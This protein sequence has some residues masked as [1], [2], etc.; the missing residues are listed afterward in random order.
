MRVTRGDARDTSF[1]PKLITDLGNGVKKRRSGREVQRSTFARF[2]GS[3][4]FRLLQQY[5]P[6]ADVS[7][8]GGATWDRQTLVSKAGTKMKSAQPFSANPKM[9]T[10]TSR[11][12]DGARCL[13]RD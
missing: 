13:F 5:L 8:R 6:L 1:Y 10:Q 2:L 3:L 9:V 12:S 11:A 7:G 4:D